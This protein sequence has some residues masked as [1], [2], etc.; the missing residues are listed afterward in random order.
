LH[1]LRRSSR[2]GRVR[3]TLQGHLTSNG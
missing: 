3:W 2:R 1:C